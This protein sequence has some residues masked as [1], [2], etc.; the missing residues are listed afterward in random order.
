MSAISEPP[1]AQQAREAAAAIPQPQPAAVAFHYAQTESFVALLDQ[2]GASLL[3]S[4][5]Q[6]NKLLVVR[7]AGGGLSTLVRTFER[8]MGMA[9]D[10]RRLALGTRSRSGCCATPRTSPRA[11]SRRAGTTPATCRAPATS[12]A[13]SA[14]TRWPGPPIWGQDALATGDELWIVNT[15]FSC[16]CTLH[17]DYSFVPRWRPPF[18]TALAAEDRCHLN[19]LALV[20]GEPQYV[21]ALGETDTP[22][23]LAGE[24]AARR[25]PDRRAQ[26]RDRG[27]RP[28]DAALAA[29]ARRPALGAGIGHR[30][31]ACSSIPPPAAGRPWPSCPA[32]RAGWRCAGPTPSSACRRSA[33]RPP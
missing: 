10:A 7:A 4:T 9:V 6:A 11:S 16:L 22:G 24:Q 14:S 21:T 3:V 20:D 23:R 12:P 1:R 17:P 29:L 27:P 19:G 8:P 25:L 18:I 15:R 32:S 33:R 26:R 31:A 2:L 30:P 5:Y 13:T 28:V